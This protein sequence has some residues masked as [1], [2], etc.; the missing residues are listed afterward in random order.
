MSLDKAIK[1]GKEHRK[2]YTKAKAVDYTCRNHGSCVYC[3][4]NRQYKNKKKIAKEDNQRAKTCFDCINFVALGEDGVHICDAEEPK[5][6]TE[7]YAPTDDFYW[8]NG[9]LFERW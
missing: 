2:P 7:D 1:S 9:T 3:Q 4:G 8:C 6:I 5:V